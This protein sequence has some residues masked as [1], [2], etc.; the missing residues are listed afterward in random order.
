MRIRL[1][2]H[3]EALASTND[4]EIMM[5]EVIVQEVAFGHWEVTT[6]NVDTNQIRVALFATWEQ[7]AAEQYADKHREEIH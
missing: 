3:Q 6:R 2:L 5:N 4:E 7:E 1:G